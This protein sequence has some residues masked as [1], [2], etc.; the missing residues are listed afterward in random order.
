MWK[1]Y[2]RDYL[3]HN[4]AASFSVIAA[5]LAASL[6]LSLLLHLAFQFWNYEIN[7]ITK[8]EGGW[9]A[10]IT[11][12]AEEDIALLRSF[13]NVKETEITVSSKELEEGEAQGLTVNLY[14]ENPKTVFQDM[15]LI[16]EQLG[17]SEE[18]IE[19]HHLL[20][21]RL[22]IHDPAD[23]NPPLLLPFLTCVLILICL[24]LLLIIYNSFALSM[25]TRIRQFGI[26]SCTGAT[27]G[28]ICLCLLQE[29]AALCI[30]P[31]LLGNLL[32]ILGARG[33]VYA[34]NATGSSIPGRIPAVWAMKPSVS[35]ASIFASAAT[36][37]FSALIPAV[38]LSRISPLEAVRQTE[39]APRRSRKPSL[40]DRKSVV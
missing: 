7:L 13:S 1:D 9:H 12:A 22:L 38:R 8:E 26:L 18:N 28:Q 30:L 4:R 23:P 15:P 39:A 16:A 17:L 11:G 25:N 14:F 21:S 6:F 32:G 35:F 37:F 40:V 5:S 10:R 36:V 29:A 19:Y 24:A 20:L 3:K 31:V 33:I 2:S 34:I 27:P